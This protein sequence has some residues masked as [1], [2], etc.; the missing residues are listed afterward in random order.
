M[1]VLASCCWAK[2]REYPQG[3]AT[4]WPGSKIAENV[5]FGGLGALPQT[6]ATCTSSWPVLLDPPNLVPGP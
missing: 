5:R 2:K 3:G 6:L 4:A 1:K